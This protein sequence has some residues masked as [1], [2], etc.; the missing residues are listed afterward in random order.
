MNL[1]CI[2]YF[3]AD[4]IRDDNKS[5]LVAVVR[6]EPQVVWY[7]RAKQGAAMTVGWFADR[8]VA[9]EA[10]LEAFCAVE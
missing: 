10:M 7:P 1:K 5:I 8:K 9:K 3:G 2:D 6:T 4:I